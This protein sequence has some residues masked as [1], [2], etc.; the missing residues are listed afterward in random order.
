[1]TC[2]LIRRS[3][4]HHPQEDERVAR[5]SVPAVI[6]VC[7]VET[8]TK[9]ISLIC[10]KITMSVQPASAIP[11]S[12]GK[13]IPA[14]AANLPSLVGQP[15]IMMGRFMSLEAQGK[16]FKFKSSDGSIILVAVE[17]GML[18]P[19]LETDSLLM[20]EGQGETRAK[21]RAHHITAFPPHTEFDNELF[22]EWVPV[23]EEDEQWLDVQDDE[24]FLHFGTDNPGD[25]HDIVTIQSEEA[26][27]LDVNR[28]NQAVGNESFNPN[29]G[30]GED[31][32]TEAEPDF[33]GAF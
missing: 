19:D 29:G 14:V 21:I 10:S 9:P 32:F 27:P 15:V 7:S 18:S 22:K 4:P 33:E 6:I 30:T 13:Y 16:F 8:Q 23:F 31:L 1:M 26:F 25:G 28:D 11:P 3:L 2:V 17:P 5:E 24:M 12:N 20:L